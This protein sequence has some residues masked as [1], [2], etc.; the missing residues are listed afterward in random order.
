MKILKALLPVSLLLLL[1]L[2]IVI[3]LIWGDKGVQV[4]GFILLGG[5]I[6]S[7]IAYGLRGEEGG[8]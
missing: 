7:A 6:V 3:G 5:L 4:F 2:S 1:A 8:C